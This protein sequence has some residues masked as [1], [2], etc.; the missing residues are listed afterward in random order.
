M[1]TN[2]HFKH[3]DI[4]VYQGKKKDGLRFLVWDILTGLLAFAVFGVVLIGVYVGLFGFVGG[5]L[6]FYAF[7]DTLAIPITYKTC[8][9]WGLI[10]VL[11]VLGFFLAVYILMWKFLLY[12]GWKILLWL[13]DVLLPFLKS[14]AN[15]IGR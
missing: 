12:V 1:D 11:N 10:P 13:L 6:L 2:K 7:A 4:Q 15:N 9:N 5:H 8:F 3:F 14:W